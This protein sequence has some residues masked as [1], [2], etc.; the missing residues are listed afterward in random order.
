MTHATLTAP[1]PASWPAGLGFIADALDAIGLSH[2]ARTLR[3]VSTPTVGAYAVRLAGAAAFGAYEALLMAERVLPASWAIPAAR[4]AL[5]KIYARGQLAAAIGFHAGEAA[6][7]CQA[8]MLSE[9]PASGVAAGP[10]IAPARIH[11]E[12]A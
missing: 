5:A 3:C 11:A 8:A 6:A 7:L 9:V 10:G 2:E 12:A 1:D 4:P